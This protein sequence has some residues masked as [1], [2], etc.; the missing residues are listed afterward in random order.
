M[1]TMHVIIATTCK[2]I[3]TPYFLLAAAGLQRVGL[4]AV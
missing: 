2:V 3:M 1:I 4:L